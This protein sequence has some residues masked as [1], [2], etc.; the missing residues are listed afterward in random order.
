MD[1]PANSPGPATA[2][3]AAIVIQRRG[4][5]NVPVSVTFATTDGTALNGADYFGQTNTVNY[6]SDLPLAQGIRFDIGA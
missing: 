3:N 4:V 6:G 1:T 2:S 5:T